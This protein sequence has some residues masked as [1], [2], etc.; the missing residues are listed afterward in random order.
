MSITESQLHE[1]L[2][3]GDDFLVGTVGGYN[4]YTIAVRFDPPLQTMAQFLALAKKGCEGPRGTLLK[5][6]SQKAIFV[7]MLS[8]ADAAKLKPGTKAFTLGAPGPRSVV[9]I[10]AIK[11]GSPIKLQ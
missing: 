2:E 3:L 8:L 10:T 5:F 4:P 9:T 11:V 6:D 1:A 7:T